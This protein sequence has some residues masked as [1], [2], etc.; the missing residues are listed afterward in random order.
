MDHHF[1]DFNSP[2]LARTLQEV[3]EMSKKSRD[4]YG[5][6]KEPLLNI[7]LDHI[8]VDE[9]HLLLRIT[10]VLTANLITE[11]TEWDIQANLENKQN[12]DTHLNKVVSCIRSCGVSFSVWRKKNADG[13]ENN[14]H[15]W[16]SL[17]GNDKKILLNKLPE[18]MKDFLRPETASK[19]IKIWE[20]FAALYKH[21]SNWQPNTSP[22]E[23][24][25]Q[26]KQWIT[27]FTSLAGLREGYERKRVTPYMHIMVGHIPWF[28]QMYKTVKIFTG[29]GVERNNDVARSIV[30]RKSNKWDSVGDVLRQESRQWRLK[31][32]EREPRTYHKRKV[33]YWEEG[34]YKK[35]K[36]NVAQEPGE[37][38]QQSSGNF[39]DVSPEPS[40]PTPLQSANFTRMT[41]PQLRQE[42]KRKGVKGISKKTRQPLV[43]LL[44][45]T[46]T[47]E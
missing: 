18:K 26:A 45:A 6:C 22:T 46:T 25:M 28:F 16:T 39:N 1:N 35:R 4:N 10:D 37:I 7:E 29:Q 5:C 44:M 21:V 9:L 12:K 36:E 3:K 31:T 11:V 24:W 32:R 38:S 20:D 8:V 42:L 40:V 2:S 19:V 41:V 30:L 17:M 33:D 23:F 14:V 34:I 13:K 27:D 47:A 15:D 43:E